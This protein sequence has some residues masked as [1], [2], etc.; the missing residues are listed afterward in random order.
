MNLSLEAE[1]EYE[2]SP[3]RDSIPG[4]TPGGSEVS[5]AEVW[6]SVRR[7]PKKPPLSCCH[8][9]SGSILRCSEWWTG[10]GLPG[11]LSPPVGNS[12]ATGHTAWR[13][14]REGS[15]LG[16]LSRARGSE[17]C[18]ESL[19]TPGQVDSCHRK[20]RMSPTSHCFSPGP[21]GKCWLTARWMVSG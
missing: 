18:C 2:R 16:P 1:G 7:C 10:N 3:A 5:W 13:R 4:L 15:L 17:T 11:Y 21:N 14:E 9:K 20:G 6:G 19:W 8:P 12:L